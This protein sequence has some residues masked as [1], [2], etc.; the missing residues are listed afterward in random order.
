[1]R[2]V[3]WV[4]LGVILLWFCALLGILWESRAEGLTPDPLRLLSLQ[5]TLLSGFIVVGVF[6]LTVAGYATLRDVKARV[7]KDAVEESRKA[8]KEVARQVAIE[9][10]PRAVREEFSREFDSQIREAKDIIDESKI[11][12]NH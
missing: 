4:P 1:M 7:L 8:A 10:T 6:S 11:W 12:P 5:V 2:L 9:E 3:V